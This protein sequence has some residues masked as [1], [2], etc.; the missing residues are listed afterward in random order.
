MKLYRTAAVVSA[1]V[2]SIQMALRSA[3][4]LSSFCEANETVAPQWERRTNDLG[5]GSSMEEAQGGNSRQREVAT[6]SKEERHKEVK[7]AI[8][9]WDPPYSHSHAPSSPPDTHCLT[10]MA[11]VGLACSIEMSLRSAILAGM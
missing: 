8:L 4:A 1:L 3:I 9:G 11:L 6:H 2:A 10:T 5:F 7:H